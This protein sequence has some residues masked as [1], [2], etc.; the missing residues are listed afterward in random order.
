MALIF[1]NP[2]KLKELRNAL[3]TDEEFKLAARFMSE[4][5]LLQSDNV[6]CFINVRDGVVTEIKSDPG[7]LEFLYKS[8]SQIV[9][10]TSAIVTSPFLY[11]S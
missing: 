6:R 3:N 4:D 10:E 7:P 11:R 1:L 9:G 5:I 2:G 8:S